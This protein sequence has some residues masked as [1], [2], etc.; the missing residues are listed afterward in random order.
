MQG[1]W[2]H[3]LDA[4]VSSAAHYKNH[5]VK[6]F[7]WKGLKSKKCE[8]LQFF[9]CWSSCCFPHAWE[10][11]RKGRNKYPHMIQ[12]DE[13]DTFHFAP[14]L[15]ESC[16][17]TFRLFS[18][19]KHKT[20]DNSLRFQNTRLQSERTNRPFF[21]FFQLKPC[22]HLL[23]KTGIPPPTLK[24]KQEPIKVNTQT[25]THLY[26]AD[27]PARTWL[28]HYI[29]FRDV[30]I[31]PWQSPTHSKNHFNEDLERDLEMAAKRHLGAN[32]MQQIF[33]PWNF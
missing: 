11:K 9:T 7:L 17:D 8:S 22:I 18:I 26:H 13:R 31:S 12:H 14:D 10:G 20:I 1:R 25:S 27:V 4:N 32:A 33:L 3:W 2:P 23:S 21:L 28:T 5:R 24:T 19:I 29:S 6:K 15:G 30:C 16:M